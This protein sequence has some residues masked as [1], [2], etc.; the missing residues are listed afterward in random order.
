MRGNSSKYVVIAIALVLPYSRSFENRFWVGQWPSAYIV[1]ATKCR[2]LIH[3]YY[4]RPQCHPNIISFS[5]TKI[6][7]LPTYDV[8]K[9][10]Q[11]EDSESIVL[12]WRIGKVRERRGEDSQQG[13][14]LCARRDEKFSTFSTLCRST[15]FCLPP[16]GVSSSPFEHLH[17]PVSRLRPSESCPFYLTG[18]NDS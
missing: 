3:P 18:S 16:C 14:Q 15:S 12:A 1:V 6:Y 8:P 4:T 11:Y 5:V 13:E 9:F 10:C 7:D 17:W 2:V